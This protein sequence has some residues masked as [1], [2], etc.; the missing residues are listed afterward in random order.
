MSNPVAPYLLANTLVFSPALQGPTGTTGPAGKSGVPV[1]LAT[2][3]GEL[4]MSA[5]QLVEMTG[6]VVPYDTTNATIP[7]VAPVNPNVGDILEFNDTSNPNGNPGG[8]PPGN[9]PTLVDPHN[10]IQI[11]QGQ[12]GIVL[13]AA[14]TPVPLLVGQVT[15]YRFQYNTLFNFSYWGAV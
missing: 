9:V 4:G 14:G 6:Q 2:T 8:S 13:A 11:Q 10:P 3:V 1:C 5:V 12:G 7:F 15:K